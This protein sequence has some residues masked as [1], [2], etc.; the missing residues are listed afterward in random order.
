MV[1][2]NRDSVHHLMSQGMT[3]VQFL[4]RCAFFVFIWIL[5]NFLLVYTLRRLDATVVMALFAC[6]VTLVYLLSWVVLH[7]QFVG[8]RVCMNMNI[9][10]IIW[11]SP[12]DHSTLSYSILNHF[13]M[14]RPLFFYLYPSFLFLIITVSIPLIS[15]L[16]I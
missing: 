10:M 15:S 3:P 4:C 2:Y 11:G 9:I 13:I 8:I 6:T 7:H 1:N 16:Q 5:T 12:S 14:F